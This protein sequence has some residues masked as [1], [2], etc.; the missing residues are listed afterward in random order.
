VLSAALVFAGFFITFFPQFILGNGGMPR[1]YF[2]YPAHFQVLH[3][4]STVGSWI[5]G[6]GMLITAGYLLHALVRG[7]RAGAN[8]WGSRSFEWRTASPPPVHNF[9]EPPLFLLDA[10]DYTQEERP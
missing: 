1:R 2:D 10:Y 7:P 8:P 6:M 3:V 9:E 5:L 4:V